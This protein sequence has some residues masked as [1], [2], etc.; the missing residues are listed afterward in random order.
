MTDGEAEIWEAIEKLGLQKCNQGNGAM[1]TNAVS[2]YLTFN[3][4]EL[5]CGLDVQRIREIV[6]LVD[7]Q[8]LEA[9]PPCVCGVVN[10]RGRII[11]VL[12]L[13]VRFGLA[14]VE[15]DK[16]SCIVVVQ[17]QGENAES[18][19]G[20]LVDRVV[21]VIE[22]NQDEIKIPPE[23]DS[24]AAPDL[25]SGVVKVEE[26]VI[27]LLDIQPFFKEIEEASLGN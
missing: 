24:G 21:E 25:I 9:A 19:G 10:L 14:R 27:I 15:P 12:D 8:S 5:I 4:G 11:P 13:K 3:L 17:E 22:P 7:I 6:G 23:D 20:L 18:L 2:M 1:I 16:Q 26:K